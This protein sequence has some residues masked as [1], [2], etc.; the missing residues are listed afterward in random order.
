VVVAAQHERRGD[1]DD[2]DQNDEEH[3]LAPLGD[4]WALAAG[5]LVPGV[6]S[7]L[8]SEIYNWQFDSRVHGKEGRS[9]V[10]MD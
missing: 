2:D 3:G 7:Q 6:C 10:I 8:T 5:R 9:P 1:D 4:P